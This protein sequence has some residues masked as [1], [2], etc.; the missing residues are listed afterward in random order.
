MLQ[1]GDKYYIIKQDEEMYYKESFNIA[2]L[3]NED[4]IIYKKDKNHILNNIYLYDDLLYRCINIE[5]FYGFVYDLEDINSKFVNNLLISEGVSFF[6]KRSQHDEFK[7]PPYYTKNLEDFK[8]IGTFNNAPNL[9]INNII[10]TKIDI[11]IQID[12]IK[13]IDNLIQYQTDIQDSLFVNKYYLKNSNI[14]AK[15]MNYQLSQFNYFCNQLP[16]LDDD[17]Y[18]FRKQ[19][20]SSTYDPHYQFNFGKEETYS[21]P[22]STSTSYEFVKNWSTSGLILV[23]KVTKDSNY[24]VLSDQ[25]Q[26]EITLGPCKLIYKEKGFYKDQAII[27]CELDL[28]I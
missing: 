4:G 2:T 18:V 1:S 10:N 17:L 14:E 24:M 13:N 20:L 3:E 12:Y 15:N 27:I 26:N 25:S 28:K 7:T 21:L 23:I 11:T 9:N 16:K 22:F 6:E 5:L 19:R 8:L